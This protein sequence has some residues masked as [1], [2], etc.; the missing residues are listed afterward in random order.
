MVKMIFAYIE[1]IAYTLAVRTAT[2]VPKP[3]MSPDQKTTSAG[4]GSQSS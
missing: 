3:E 2:A 1:N 4:A